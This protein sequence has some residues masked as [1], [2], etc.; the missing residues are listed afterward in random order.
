MALYLHNKRNNQ[1]SE[2]KTCRMGE[3]FANY[4]FDKRLKSRIINKVSKASTRCNKTVTMGQMIW[5]NVLKEW[6]QMGNKHMKKCSTGQ[7]A[8]VHCSGLDKALPS[9]PKQ[10][11]SLNVLGGTWWRPTQH[12]PPSWAISMHAGDLERLCPANP[13]IQ[14]ALVCLLQAYPVYST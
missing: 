13:S 8:L 6:I 3:I 5:I 12:T 4:S 11:G 9:N 1:E 10:P 2:K 14:G 7:G